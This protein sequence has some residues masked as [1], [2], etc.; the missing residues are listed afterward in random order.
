MIEFQ[1]TKKEYENFP[2][3]FETNMKVLDFYQN[4]IEYPFFIIML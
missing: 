1:L 2:D 4:F 3:D